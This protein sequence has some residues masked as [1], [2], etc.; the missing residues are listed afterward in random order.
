[1][2]KSVIVNTFDTIFKNSNSL[3][4]KLLIPI[5]IISVINYF[6]PQFIT[7][8]TIKNIESKNFDFNIFLIPFIL[9]F[10]LTMTNISI[11]ITTH[12]IAILG[13]DSVP[14]FGSYIFGLRE[15]KFLFNSIL[16]GFAIVL[17]VVL[18]ALIPFVGVFLAPIIALLLTSRLAIIFPSISCDKNMGFIEAWRKTKN[19][20]LILIFAV[21]IFPL[22]FSISVGLVYSL[23]IEFLMKLVSSHLIFLYSILNVFILVFSISSLSSVYLQIVPRPLNRKIKE[24][25]ENAKEII[26]SS[27]KDINK[28]TIDDNHKVTFESLKKEIE[29]QYHKL[30]FTEIAYNRSNSFI[31]KNPDE[32]ESYVSLRHDKNEYIIQ[33]NK[34]VK[35]I[36]NIMEQMATKK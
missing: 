26:E 15:F 1:M 11:A 33:T 9:L 4:Q 30:G 2:Y 35:P 23:V 16:M 7:E 13:E 12:R 27:R 3:I 24:T 14:K 31:L 25:K 28:I 8:E 6:L 29:D 19:Y 5:I 10:I 21:V 36:L 32:I 18:I 17:P 20:K 34:T 22:I